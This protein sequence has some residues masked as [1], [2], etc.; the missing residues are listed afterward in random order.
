[1]LFALGDLAFGAVKWI[2]DV[3]YEPGSLA[4]N[5]NL[6]GALLVLATLT[7]TVGGLLV[8]AWR[9]LRWEP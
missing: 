6:P 8:V 2:F 7:W 1:M 4:A 5:T 9:Y 3:P